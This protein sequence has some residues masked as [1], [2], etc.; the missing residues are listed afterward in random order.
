MQEISQVGVEQA[1]PETQTSEQEELPARQAR[2]H[3]LILRVRSGDTEAFCALI[4]PY[5]RAVYGL[6]RTMITNPP[7]AEDVVQDAVLCA[8]AKLHQLRQL[9]SF[10]GWLMQIAVNEAR[11]KLRRNQRRIRTES[12]TEYDEG[13]RLL[14]LDSP[15]IDRR[16]L[17]SLEADNAQMRDQL[18]EAL[19]RLPHAFARYLS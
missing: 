12:L 18:R 2:D 16:S 4:Q 7:D 17:P 9:Q 14:P 6:V 8:F 10:R 19:E 5:L 13:T 15:L 11:L 3:E 1:I